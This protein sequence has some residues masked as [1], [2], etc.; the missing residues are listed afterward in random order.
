MAKK[1]PAAVKLGRRGGK[2]AARNRTAQER[3]EQA[4]KAANTRWAKR[5]SLVFPGTGAR[6]AAEI[7]LVMKDLK[8]HAARQEDTADEQMPTKDRRPRLA[9]DF[10]FSK[11]MVYG[12]E[13]PLSNSDLNDLGRRFDRMLSSSFDQ[14]RKESG[15][16]SAGREITLNA[17]DEYVFES[18][19][20]YGPLVLLSHYV[21]RRIFEWQCD[22]SG[23][24]KLGRLGPALAKAAKIRHRSARG[25]I[26]SKH[27][28][29]KQ[30]IT[31]EISLLRARLVVAWPKDARAIIKFISDELFR[32]DCRYLH[33]ARNHDSLIEFLLFHKDVAVRFRGTFKR[34]AGRTVG[35]SDDVGPARFVYLWIA[36][37]ENK[38]EDSVK[39]ELSRQSK[40]L[41][42]PIR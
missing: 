33:L 28:H 4:R 26:T 9:E 7:P 12:A 32:P 21:L 34:G 15:H 8:S 25:R 2:V 11:W 14:L 40:Q 13:L 37:S 10:D 24:K 39:V 18:I 31:P 27:A 19:Q 22:G 6:L 23:I 41:K 5:P 16:E 38:T 3:A 20:E 30:F 1:D 42:P 17:W 29:F 35:G 36:H